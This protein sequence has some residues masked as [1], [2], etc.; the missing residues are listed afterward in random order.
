[1]FNTLLHRTHQY[2]AKGPDPS[3]LKKSVLDVSVYITTHIVDN[4]LAMNF[5]QE[6]VN[7]ILAI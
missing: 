3:G 4:G 5:N 7:I 1:M 6:K 2:Q